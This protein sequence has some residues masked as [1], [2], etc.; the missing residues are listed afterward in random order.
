MNHYVEKKLASFA[1]SWRYEGSKKPQ[2]Y[3][4]KSMRKALFFV[5]SCNDTIFIIF[6]PSGCK[7]TSTGEPL[8]TDCNA[9]LYFKRVDS[10]ECVKT[11]P[12]GFKENDATCVP[13]KLV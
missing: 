12:E 6:L 7:S 3:V 5:Y 11:C 2:A 13:S 10:G 1:C 4:D 8:P 9:C